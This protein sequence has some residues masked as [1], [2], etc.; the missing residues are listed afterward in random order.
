MSGFTYLSDC[1]AADVRVAGR[2]TNY[3]V[4]AA[5]GWACDAIPDEPVDWDPLNRRWLRWEA[6]GLDVAADGKDGKR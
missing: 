6:P 4:C 3:Y 2:T 1:C 5:C